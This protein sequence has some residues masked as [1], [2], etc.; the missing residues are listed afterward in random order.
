MPTCD[1]VIRFAT[2]LVSVLLENLWL[3]LRLAAIASPSRGERHLFD[4][5]PFKLFYD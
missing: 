2:L 5:F 4:E 3:V 1:S